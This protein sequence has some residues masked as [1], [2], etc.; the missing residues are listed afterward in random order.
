LL[1]GTFFGGYMLY[2]VIKKESEDDRDVN[3]AWTSSN[4]I[5]LRRKVCIISKCSFAAY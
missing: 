4:T 2:Q 3:L 1:A 5:N